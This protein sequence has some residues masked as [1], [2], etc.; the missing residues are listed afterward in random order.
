MQPVT[1]SVPFIFPTPPVAS[2]GPPPLS[3]SMAGENQPTKNPQRA[4]CSEH[5]PL[6][7]LL[8]PRLHIP[9]NLGTSAA[10]PKYEQLITNGRRNMR[11][12][13]VLF[14]IAQQRSQRFS[15]PSRAWKGAGRCSSSASSGSSPSGVRAWSRSG[16]ELGRSGSSKVSGPS[17]FSIKTSLH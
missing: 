15:S 6:I 16:T 11:K 8:N 17:P 4:G 9:P 5:S 2:V 1:V 14:L 3:F 7:S 13:L 12:P 10:S